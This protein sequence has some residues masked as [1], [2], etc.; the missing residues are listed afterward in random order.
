MQIFWTQNFQI[1]LK[2]FH[3]FSVLTTG[4]NTM[5]HHH[6]SVDELQKFLDQQYPDRWIGRGGPRNWPARSPDL[7]PLDFFLWG[8]VKNVVY[9]QPIYTEEQLR[10]CIQEAFATITSEMVINSKRSL[11]RWARLCLQM[12]GGHFEH[13]L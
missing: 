6:I 4:F 7:N 9:K 8:H 2:T 12:N 5:A 13:L 10:G 11:L 3:L 1:C